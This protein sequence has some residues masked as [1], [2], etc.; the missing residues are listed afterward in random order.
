MRLPAA[1]ALALCLACATSFAAA[2]NTYQV[3]GEVLAVTDDV[4]TVKK[5]KEK[6][7]VARSPEVKVEGG[8]L[9]VGAKVTI[10]YRM[11]ATSV[12]VKGK[13]PAKK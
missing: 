2:P 3:T 4:V 8:E 1:A 6:W 7:E 10:E 9:V 11:A 13:A 12:T 5:G